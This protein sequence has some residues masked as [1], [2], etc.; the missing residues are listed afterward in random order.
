MRLA[1]IDSLKNY[2]VQRQTKED[3]L[4]GSCSKKTPSGSGRPI[5]KLHERSR[6]QSEC[7]RWTN[8]YMPIIYMESTHYYQLRLGVWTSEERGYRCGEAQCDSAKN[9]RNGKILTSQ[10]GSWLKDSW[11]AEAVHRR[12]R[13]RYSRDLAD[14]P[15]TISEDPVGLSRWS[16]SPKKLKH[17]S[18][19]GLSSEPWA[20]HL[21]AC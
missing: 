13:W 5:I 10:T 12:S 2:V 21:N 17:W 1:G 11:S 3:A 8:S 15:A 20:H 7:Q 16:C 19:G 18:S 6:D 4:S 14:S 9:G